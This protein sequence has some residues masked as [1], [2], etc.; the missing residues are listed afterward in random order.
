MKNLL[1]IKL[2][3]LLLS[4]AHM[5]S[6]LVLYGSQ[7]SRSP[8]VNWYLHEI[9]IPFTMGNRVE[10]PHPF[11]QIP[12]LKDGETVIFESGAILMYLAD[13]YH[14]LDTPEKRSGYHLYHPHYHNHYHL[15]I[16]YYIKLYVHGLYGLIVL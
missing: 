5:S 1:I 13:K 3:L 11:G 6:S 10:N 12:C 14:Q 8:L 2:L 15:Y 7:G 4:F 16:Y 9:D